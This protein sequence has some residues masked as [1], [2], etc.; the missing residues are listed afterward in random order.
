MQT[1]TLAAGTRR[2]MHKENENESQDD[3]TRN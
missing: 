3:A 2:P 1:R